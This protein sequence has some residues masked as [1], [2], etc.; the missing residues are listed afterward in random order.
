MA[1]AAEPCALWQPLQDIRPWRTG[2]DE[3]FWKSARCTLWQLRHTGASVALASTGSPRA[4]CILWQSVHASL[5]RSC[6]PAC[7]AVRDVP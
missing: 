7:Q 1:G 4:W 5:L 3:G 2:C 6:A